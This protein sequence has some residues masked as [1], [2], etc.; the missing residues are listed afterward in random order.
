MRGGRWKMLVADN[1]LRLARLKNKLLAYGLSP[2]V[3][4]CTDLLF[5]PN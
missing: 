5:R 4:R 2:Q 1:Y 3:D